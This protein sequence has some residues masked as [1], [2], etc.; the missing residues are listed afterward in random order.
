MW[1]VSSQM[2][3]QRHEEQLGNQLYAKYWRERNKYLVTYNN[4]ITKMDD[5]VEY[6]IVNYVVDT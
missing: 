3:Y 5:G 1:W 6:D 4:Q 2:D